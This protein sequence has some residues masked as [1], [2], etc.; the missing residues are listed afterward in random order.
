MKLSEISKEKLESLSE[1]QIIKIVYGGRRDQGECADIALVLGG[2]PKHCG[3]RAYKAAELFRMGRI[4]TLITSGGVKWNFDGREISEAE[5]L[6][7]IL[8][9]EGVPEEAILVEDRSTTTVENLLYCT[10]LFDK[11][12]KLKNVKTVMIVTSA[13][14]LRR[15][16]G[17][18]ELLLPRTMKVVGSPATVSEDPL[19]YLDTEHRRF[20]T[21]RELPL[22]KDL[23][24]A[25]LME[26]IEF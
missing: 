5:Y 4:R 22:I 9:Q 19:A 10:I 20:Q 2:N 12:F 13:S 16:L 23:I 26:D 25:G 7:D 17:L 6:A 18:A 15:S 24:D 11:V 14:H 3:E 21:M 8:R 1:G